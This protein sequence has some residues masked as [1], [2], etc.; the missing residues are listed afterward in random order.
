MA[1]NDESLDMCQSYKYV[2]SG[3]ETKNPTSIK[4]TEVDILLVRTS[5][6]EDPIGETEFSTYALSQDNR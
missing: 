4:Y 3:W 1:E 2:V 5:W 6:P